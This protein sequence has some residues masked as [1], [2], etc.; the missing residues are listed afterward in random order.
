M[1]V[2]LKNIVKDDLDISMVAIFPG[3]PKSEVGRA[4]LSDGSFFIVYGKI[5]IKCPFISKKRYFPD[6]RKRFIE[7]VT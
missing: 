4:L 1:L 3:D 6:M 2:D 5:M 7:K